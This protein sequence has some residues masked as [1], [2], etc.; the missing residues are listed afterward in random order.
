MALPPSPRPVGDPVRES[1][2]VLGLYIRAQLLIALILAVLYAV[3]F[4]IARVPLWPVIAVIG[5]FSTLI[6][7]VGSLIPLVLAVIANLIGDRNLEH[8]AIAFG[9]WLAIQALEGFYITPKL[10]SKPLGLKP[11]PVFVALLAGSFLFGPLGLLLAVPLLAVAGVFWRY[12]R[13]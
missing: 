13:R 6:P 10:L 8:L 11:L 3:G 7:R 9:A 5:G 1:F 4:A 12:F 2:R